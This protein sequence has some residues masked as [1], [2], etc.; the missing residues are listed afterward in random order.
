MGVSTENQAGGQCQKIFS[1]FALLQKDPN[2]R[3]GIEMWKAKDLGFDPMGNEKKVVLG[4]HSSRNR[5]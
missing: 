3:A 2:Y 4:L 1:Q 5:A